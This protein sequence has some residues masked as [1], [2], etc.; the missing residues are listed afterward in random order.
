MEIVKKL[1]DGAQLNMEGIAH[2]FRTPASAGAT[3]D[4]KN[5][6]GGSP[7]GKDGFI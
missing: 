6:R 3:L 4:E 5:A 7:P 2:I 1:L